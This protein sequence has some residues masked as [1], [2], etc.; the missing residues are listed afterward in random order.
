MGKSIW[1]KLSC[2]ALLMCAAA[3]AQ[4]L[5]TL[6]SFSGGTNKPNELLQGSDGNFYGVT[7]Y[8]Q[9]SVV[10]EMTPAGVLTTLLTEDVQSIA[11]SLLQSS[12]GNFYGTSAYNGAYTFGTVFKL[13]PAKILSALHQ[14]RGTDGADPIGGM[15][16]G[17]DGNF[18]G[19]TNQGG[20]N[21]PNASLGV[22]PGTVFKI[23]PAGVFSTIYNFSGPD[24][25]APSG[26]LIQGS[27]GNFY[28]TTQNGGQGCTAATLGYT[29]C[30]T[31]FQITPT[32]ELTTLHIFVSASDGA[33][34]ASGLIQGKDGNFYGSTS[35]GGPGGFGTLFRITST[36]LFTALHSFTGADGGNPQAN[37]A[38]VQAADGNFYGTTFSQGNNGQ[39]P[40]S[41]QGTIFKMTPAGTL[42]TLY[43]FCSQANCADGAGG[44]SLIIGSDGNFYGT[45]WAGG[46]GGNGT[47]FKFVAAS[48]NAPVITAS[49]GVVSGA[50]FQ[51]GVAANSWITITGTNLAAVTDTWNNSITNGNLPTKLDGVSVMVGGQP[52]YIAYVSPTQI[53]AVAPNIS[54][55]TVPVTVTTSIGVSAAV[56]ATAQAA[57]PA[58]SN[59]EITRWPA[60]WITA[61]PSRAAR[62]PAS[63]P[64]RPSQ[65]TSS[66]S[67][68]P[69]SDPPRRQRWWASKCRPPRPITPARPS[70]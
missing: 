27:D 32:G 38:M 66:S 39:T 23:S 34:P 21:N 15:V 6:T 22:G 70:R 63:P 68:A 53:N 35:A 5:T 59:G 8:L 3:P 26:T 1:R 47:V 62:S 29:G 42:T 58:F 2:A 67:G 31:V 49:N 4:T 28:G 41:I 10:F 7:K 37:T 14:F 20:A 40:Q 48:P 36:G 60:S 64:R 30:G 18:Y 16:L 54:S 11:S 24:G 44:T 33:N 12:D 13:T 57:Q 69:A 61:W 51:P 9:D 55:G 45:T 43:N 19:T 56:N 65:A 25:A 52:A 50:S 46:V 17:S